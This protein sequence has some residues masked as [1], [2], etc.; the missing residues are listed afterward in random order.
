MPISSLCLKWN[1]LYI[2]SRTLLSVYIF[3]LVLPTYDVKSD[4]SKP[5]TT[6][7][8]MI[9]SHTFTFVWYY[10]YWTLY[11]NAQSKGETNWESKR[12]YIKIEMKLNSTAGHLTTTRTTQYQQ[13]TFSK[14]NPF[15]KE[16][17]V[18][19]LPTHLLIISL[20]F[21]Q[22]TNFRWLIKRQWEK[23]F[24]IR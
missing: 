3:T 14:L 8:S 4:I 10:F 16:E 17:L 1:I 15:V 21:A 18:F 7:I 24:I 19:Y 22:I 13:S 5:S 23:S 11:L 12:A 20:P 9:S 6:L 2:S